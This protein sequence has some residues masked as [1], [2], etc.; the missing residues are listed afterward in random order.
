M[1]CGS[2]PLIVIT[3]RFIVKSGHEHLFF[4]RAN[5]QAKATLDNES[6]CKQFDVCRDPD[7]PRRILLYE[8]YTSDAAFAAHLKTP[9]FLAFD[10]DTR[11]FVQEKHIERWQRA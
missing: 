6:D 9:Y 10:A 7:D 4:G 1:K 11:D 8:I 5:V 3:V 2:L